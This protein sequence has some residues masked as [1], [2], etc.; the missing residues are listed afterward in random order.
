VAPLQEDILLKQAHAISEEMIEWRRDFHMHPEIGFELHRTSKIVADELEKLGYRVRRGVGKTGVIAEIGE[1]GKVVAIRAD[2]DALPILEQNEFEYASTI[3]GAMHACGHDSHTAMALGAAWIL[4]KEKLSGRVRFLFQPCEETTD[5]EGKSGAQRMSAEGAMDGVD[6]IIAQ[7]VDPLQPV[8]TI[9]INAGPSSG[10][11]DSWYATVSGK[12]GHGAHPDKTIDPFY[13]L[14]HVILALNGIV[15]RRINPFEPAVVS[16]GSINGGL[17]ENVIPE[18]VK[19]TGTLRFTDERVHQQ[20]HEEMKRAFEI[21]KTLGGEYTLRYE[22]G[23]PP[24][25]NDQFVSDVIENTGK[26]LLGAENVH[27][28]Q[29]TLGAEDF[30]EFMK[31]APGAMFTLGTR[32]QGH[33]NYLLHH[34]RFELDERA[35]P[36]GTAMLAETAKRFLEL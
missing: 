19:L 5:E 16:I 28:I 6:F 35:L 34:P 11:V 15:S 20:I 26:E 32:K 10:G 23:G 17:T 9:G 1:G 33:E 30:G 22:I 36:I 7:H 18:T 2:M 27:E 31:H 14:A 25:I 3:P 13:L 24:M 4:S 29:K 8:G 21:A 12:G